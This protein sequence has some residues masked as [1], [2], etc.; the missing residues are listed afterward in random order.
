MIHLSCHIVVSKWSWSAALL[1][2]AILYDLS[3]CNPSYFLNK[4][5]DQQS[6]KKAS[7]QTVWIDSKWSKYQPTFL[8]GGKIGRYK[9]CVVAL[10]QQPQRVR[11][12]N[13]DRITSTKYSEWYWK[14]IFPPLN[15]DSGSI[16]VKIHR[17]SRI[18]IL[19]RIQKQLSDHIFFWCTT[20]YLYEMTWIIKSLHDVITATC[21]FNPLLVVELCPYY[22]AAWWMRLVTDC[23]VAADDFLY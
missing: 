10:F 9:T 5:T 22:V 7:R 16:R 3:V 12:S 6:R 13:Q 8:L 18:C 15:S 21:I 17:Y 11:T 20:N 2:N 14:W 19:K 4:F 1:W 23:F